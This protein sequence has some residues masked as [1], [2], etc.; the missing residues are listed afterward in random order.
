MA[1]AEP[2]RQQVQVCI[3]KAG[4]PVGSLAYVRQGHRKNCALAYDET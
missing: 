3:G 1:V 4:L 2:F